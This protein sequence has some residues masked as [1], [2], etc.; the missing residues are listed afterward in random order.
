MA[1]P[2]PDLVDALLRACLTVE[3]ARAAVLSGWGGEY[4][5]DGGS[6]GKRAAILREL[7]EE[8]GLA[9]SDHV[10]D[11]HTAWMRSLAGDRPD[12][13]PLGPGVVHRLAA[14]IDIY[15]K[16]FL[17][18]RAEEFERLG[19]AELRFPIP[20]RHM[21]RTEAMLER[22]DLPDGD[23]FVVLTDMHIG[24]RG[25]EELSRIAA[26]EINELA[27]SF[28]VVPGDITDDG[29][30][31]QFELA[32]EILSGLDAPFHGVLGNHDAVRRST[33]QPEGHALY[34]QSFGTA[35]LDVVL[36]CGPLQVALVDTTDPAPSPFP[37]WDLARGGFRD[38][39]GGTNGGALRPGQAEALAEMIDPHRPSLIV[40]HHEWQPFTA[41]PPIMFGL[42]DTDS[43]ELARVLA[44][45]RLVGIVAGHT[46]RS[47]LTQVEGGISQLEV[48]S[49]KD[50]PFCYTVV[51]VNG[52]GAHV[53]VRQVGAP[54]VVWEYAHQVPPIYLGY[55]FGPLS[56]PEYTFALE[57]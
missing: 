22:P 43:A 45:H 30:P 55:V 42:R 14:W 10:L 57:S 50:W 12:V 56:A 16:P 37:D 47:A 23:R 51:T 49:L 3:S 27:P 41:F 53:T 28:V 9:V 8:R 40:C 15:A 52:E 26:G 39:A 17:G 35:P 29:E 4:G 2:R 7:C 25:T 36:E 32:H 46:H 33:V 34:E 11:G 13:V 20:P 18:D 6:A 31:E 19:E 5:P 48:P 1:E 38:D 54:D 44:G 24:A 21:E